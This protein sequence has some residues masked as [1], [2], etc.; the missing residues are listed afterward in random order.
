MTYRDLPYH[1]GH[2]A[3]RWET[4]ERLAGRLLP[5]PALARLHPDHRLL[6]VP[7]GALHAIAWAALRVGPGWLIERAIVHVAPSLSA[8]QSIG[9]ATWP[10][11]ALLVGCSAFGG[12]ADPL[13]GVE[14]EVAAVAARWP[15]AS[16]QVQNER[17]TRAALLEW[18]ASG[19]LA[20]YGLIHIASHAQLVPAHGWAAHVKLWD[21]DLLLSEVA[22]LR[23]DGALV[24]LSACD[25]AASVVLPGE[26][27]L[28]LNWAFLAAGA[29]AV[30][31]SLWPVYD[32]AALRLMLLFYEALRT[33]GDGAAA[34]AQAQRQQI[35]VFQ[36]HGDGAAAPD[37]WASFVVTGGRV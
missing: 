14:A 20:S 32:Q 9:R 12:R 29:S 6:I 15:S 23:L 1:L 16:Q 33:H 7:A 35:A 10:G 24:T 28:S 37:C 22:D 26:E 36:Q 19:A 2:A 21:D 34:L 30:L 13:P 31:A 17:A 27:I 8:W 3:R 18:S 4:L 5:A 11:A 25:G